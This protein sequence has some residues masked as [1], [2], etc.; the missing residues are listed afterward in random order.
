MLLARGALGGGLHDHVRDVDYRSFYTAG[1]MVLHGGRSELETLD[2]Q[3]AWQSRLWPEI[4]SERDLMP[5]MNPP[6][7]AAANAPFAALDVGPAYAAWTLVL[8]LVLALVVALLQDALPDARAQ[9]LL[10]TAGFAFPPVIIALMQGQPSFVIALAFI[11]GWRELKAER[12]VSAGLALSLLALKPH[13]V[14]VPAL[15]LALKRKG[16]A[17]AGMAAGGALLAL[18]S[19]ALVGVQGAR[20]YVHLLGTAMANQSVDVFRPERTQTLRGFL[21]ALAGTKDPAK[22][23]LPWLVG[24]A[25]AGVALLASVAR[26]PDTKAARFDVEWAL[27][28]VV[29]LFVAP[30]LHAHDVSVLLVPAVLVLRAQAL[31]PDLLAARAWLLVPAGWLAVWVHTGLVVALRPDFPALIV[32]VEAAAIVALALSSLETKRDPGG[33]LDH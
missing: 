32:P 29:A 28:I 8:A 3:F 23:A 1:Y 24:S 31:E 19:V 14:F 16:R 22:V 2:G 12:P 20:D 13:L 6:F 27:A 11:L 4:T 9:R 18:V 17:L 15:V 26:T 7:F 25:L 10:V 30:H 33:G 5:I 21:C